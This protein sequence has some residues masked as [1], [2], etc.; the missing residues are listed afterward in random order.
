M[1]DLCYLT[2]FSV[3]SELIMLIFISFL[4]TKFEIDQLNCVKIQRF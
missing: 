1:D 4:T 3:R 2:R